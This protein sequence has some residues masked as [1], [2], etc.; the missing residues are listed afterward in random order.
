MSEDLQEV[1]RYMNAVAKGDY[2]MQGLFAE[3]AFDEDGNLRHVELQ[4][5]AEILGSKCNLYYSQTVYYITQCMYWKNHKH[6]SKYCGDDQEMVLLRV[7]VHDGV[8]ELSFP[9]PFL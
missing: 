8:L 1:H 7:G 6:N 2:D 4:N 3:S 9:F 5:L